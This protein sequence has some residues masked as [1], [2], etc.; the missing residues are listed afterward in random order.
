MS[1]EIINE[2]IG[3]KYDILS[4]IGS[5]GSSIVYLAKKLK[6][7]ERYAIKTI[8]TEEKDSLKLLEREIK[9]LK[10]LNHSSIVRFIED[11]YEQRHNFIYLVL[12]YLDGVNI[13]TYFDQGVDIKT[14]IDLLLQILDAI[15]HAHSKEVIHRDIK[16]E[17]IMVVENSEQ[18][19]AKVLDFGISIIT[20]TI[21]TNTI[22]RYHTP[23]FAAPEQIQ[24]QGVSRDSDIYSLGMTFLYLLSASDAK[25]DFR[26]NQDKNFLYES[27]LASLN[28]TSNHGES[29]IEVLKRATDANRENRPKI[30]K[31]RKPLESIKDDLSAKLTVVFSLTSNLKDKISDLNKYD[32]QSLKVKRDVESKLQSNSNIIHIIRIKG[33]EG[34]ENRLTVEIGVE[35]TSYIYRGFINR[36]K[37]DEIVLFAELNFVNPQQ[38]E[39]LFRN[40]IAVKINPIINVGSSPRIRQDLSELINQL[41]Q[42]DQQVKNEIESNKGV[43]NTFSR[44]QSVIEIEEKIINERKQS[45]SYS[46]FEYDRENQRIIITLKKPISLDEF[47]QITSP[48]L[49]VTISIKQQ[50]PPY[51]ESQ[52]P[53][54]KIID[55]DKSRNAEIVEKLQI[56]IAEFRNLDVFELILEKGK[57]ETD[58]KAQES[59]IGRR[60][61]ALRAIK[62]GDSENGTLCKVISDPSSS[63]AIEPLLINRFFNEQLDI[64][65]QA[66]VCKALATEDIFLIQGPP[67]TGKTSVITEIVLRILTDHPSDK[68]LI[69]SQS[70]IAVD[71]VLTKLSGIKLDSR[72]VRVLR[73]GREEKIEEDA[74][75][76]EIEKAIINWQ[77][78]IRFQ[79]SNH[80]QEYENQHDEMLLG[81]KKL[82][83]IESIKTLSQQVQHISENITQ[84]VKIFNSELF[85]S[86]ENTSSQQAAD[87]ACE[88]IYEKLLIEEKVLGQIKEYVEKFGIEY[89]DKKLLSHWID[90]EYKRLQSILGDNNENYEKVLKLRNLKEEWNEKLKR[91]QIDLVSIFLDGVN[92]VGAT[93]LGIANLKDFKFDWVIVD[94]AGRST[95]PETFVPMT[96]GKKIILVGDHQQLPPIIDREL[97]T[98][99][100]GEKD[101]ERKVLETSLF[102]YLYNELPKSNKITLNHQYRMHPDIGNLVSDLFYE[103]KVLSERV[104]TNTKLHQFSKFSKSVYWVSTSDVTSDKSKERKS[105]TSY[106]NSYEANLIKSILNQI[107]H[108]Y[109]SSNVHKEVGIIAGYASQISV[110]EATVAPHDKNLWNNLD[111]A[112]HTVDAFQGR[113]CDIIIYD[114]V[115]N[116]QQ[117]DLGFTSDYRRL[118]VALSRAKQ[119]LII[120]GNDLMAYEG[121]TPNKLPNPFEKLIEYIDSNP[122]VCERLV[123]SDFI[124]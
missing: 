80:W 65:Q 18:P 35:A 88:M 50:S 28:A 110:L 60:R 118:N 53:V 71:N 43:D 31:I 117:K 73:I 101:I 79:S 47:E 98:R 76:F 112:I 15:S 85:I 120:V 6:T 54:G 99:A 48:P 56:S 111:I 21:L 109:Q 44:W 94:E 27:A 93:C 87:H 38:S 30:D 2:V 55:G 83:D 20:T 100:L 17:N 84:A 113:E 68:V 92:V 52:W 51:R 97:Q 39:R 62:Y 91:K 46:S 12:E 8:S 40:G 82:S 66:A 74:R 59:E 75:K 89:P 90:Q 36:D 103:G 104:D 26:E 69:S 19:L 67:G 37:P 121:R 34:Q 122:K 49:P 42:K 70:N 123:S 13:K 106:S 45:F 1:I 102:E 24:L 29:L 108:D 72:D 32:G 9:T 61:K 57:I 115:R 86:I 5:G 95:A 23:L 10:R 22:R 124:K 11:G 107:Q 16:P 41:L 4:E 96:R 33:E 78:S 77:D 81:V 64:S 114:L 7:N 63:Q 58:F 119:L 116:N 3:G 25:N 105:G 14:K